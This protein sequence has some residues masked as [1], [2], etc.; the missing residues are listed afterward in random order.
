MFQIYNSLLYHLIWKRL[1]ATHM[2]NK[3]FNWAIHH[4]TDHLVMR[5]FVSGPPS[6][7][8]IHKRVCDRKPILRKGS[9]AVCGFRTEFFEKRQFF[10]S[11]WEIML[12]IGKPK[13]RSMMISN[14]TNPLKESRTNLYWGVR[15]VHPFVCGWFVI[16]LWCVYKLLV[17][18]S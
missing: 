10:G 7:C 15:V 2:W 5:Q 8:S 16:S 13:G 14:A 12:F 18:V 1:G 17:T 11:S 9:W 6:Y 4:F 3:A